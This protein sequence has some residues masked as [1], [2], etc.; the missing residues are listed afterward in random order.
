MSIVAKKEN[1][2]R[3]VTLKHFTAEKKYHITEELKEAS[4]K[5]FTLVRS[6]LYSEEEKAKQVYRDLTKDMA[7]P[8]ET[9]EKED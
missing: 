9:K 4:E 2:T 5:E 8:K 6:N 1:E 3:R 7:E